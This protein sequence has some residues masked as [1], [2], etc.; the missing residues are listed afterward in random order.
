LFEQLRE[1]LGIKG[2]ASVDAGNTARSTTRAI[3]AVASNCKAL[4]IFE[5][6]C[7]TFALLFGRLPSP[8]RSKLSAKFKQLTLSL[9][10]R[11]S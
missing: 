7:E 3:A 9:G 2:D 6:R 8:V 5:I 10:L 1:H 4:N 11:F